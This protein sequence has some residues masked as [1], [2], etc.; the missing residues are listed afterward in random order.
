MKHAGGNYT[1]SNWC[2]GNS[3][4]RIT[5][6]TG[7]HGSWMTSGHHP[8]YSIVENSQNS[9]QSPGDLRRFAVTQTPVK[10]HQLMLM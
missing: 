8:K 7:G 10:Y 2:V 6:G 9:D 1:N 5:K 4:K 3:N